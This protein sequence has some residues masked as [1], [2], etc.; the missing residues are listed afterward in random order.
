MDFNSGELQC[1]ATG[2][3]ALGLPEHCYEFGRTETIGNEDELNFP[4]E[5]LP[6]SPL[7]AHTEYPAT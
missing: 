2:P 6:H 1:I 7:L 3:T 4:F 5:N